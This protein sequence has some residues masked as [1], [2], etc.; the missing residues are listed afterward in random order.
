MFQCQTWVYQ[1]S[2]V[3]RQQQTSLLH[4][5][6]APAPQYSKNNCFWWHTGLQHSS[7]SPPHEQMGMVSL[8]NSAHASF[9]PAATCL[10]QLKPPRLLNLHGDVQGSQLL[11]L[12]LVPLH[13]TCWWRLMGLSSSLHARENV[14]KITESKKK[15]QTYWKRLETFL[16]EVYPSEN[17]PVHTKNRPVC[18]RH[19]AMGQP[20]H[21]EAFHLTVAVLLAQKSPPIKESETEST[22]TKYFK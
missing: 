11:F 2:G 1:S 19:L 4:R 6:V 3:Q 5:W 7:T 8:T 13:C 10:H 9:L 18:A 14:I 16:I 22:T 12:P 15:S 21:Q 20:Q 17:R